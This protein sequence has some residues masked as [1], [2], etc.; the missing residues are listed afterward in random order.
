MIQGLLRAVKSPA[1][2]VVFSIV[3][4]LGLASLFRRTCHALECFLFQAPPWKET[5][6]SVYSYGGSCYR[7][8][9]RAGPC[10]LTG[11]RHIEIA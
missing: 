11:A 6:S 7:F 9:P 8:K 1:G 10:K 4:G 5:I 3:L 2:R